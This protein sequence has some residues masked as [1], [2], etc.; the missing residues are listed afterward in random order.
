MEPVTLGFAALLGILLPPL[1]SLL[2]STSWRTEVKQ[3]VAVAASLVVAVGLAFFDGGVST[4][5]WEAFAAN[6]AVI[7]GFS[8]VVYT[9]YFGKTRVN[10]ELETK[11]VK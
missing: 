8:Q 2:K 5:T 10:A 6:A 3:L 4:W 9:Q 11:L 7:F 1:V